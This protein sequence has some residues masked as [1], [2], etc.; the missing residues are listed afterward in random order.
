MIFNTSKS[1]E[2]LV[3]LWKIIVFALCI[4]MYIYYFSIQNE[5]YFVKDK[6]KWI[7]KLIVIFT[8]FVNIIIVLLLIKSG[9]LL[10]LLIK[11]KIK[12][13]ENVFLNLL[14]FRFSEFE[15]VEILKEH[16]NESYK[17]YFENKRVLWILFKIILGIPFAFSAWFLIITT[18][19]VALT[20]DT[21]FW[22][23]NVVGFVEFFAIGMSILIFLM[24]NINIV[25]LKYTRSKKIRFSIII[26]LLFSFRFIALYNF[27]KKGTRTP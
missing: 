24:K 21:S 20:E 10:K 6:T 16:T 12:N 3:L 7:L 18:P 1:R 26:Y 27:L 5:D 19:L 17:Q 2:V 11:R 8:V 13:W 14:N 23:E 4:G 15:E 22:R 9:I 25:R